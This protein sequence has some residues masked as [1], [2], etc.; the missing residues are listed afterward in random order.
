MFTVLKKFESQQDR[1]IER[2]ERKI[3]YVRGDS[4]TLNTRMDAFEA[5]IAPLLTADAQC[6]NRYCRD[7]R[8]YVLRVYR[9]GE[10]KGRD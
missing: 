3:K 10:R 6:K 5:K 4:H 8:N 2:F 7:R 9:Y 1:L